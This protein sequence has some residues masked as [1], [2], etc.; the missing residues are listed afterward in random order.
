[1]ANKIEA[2]KQARDGL[3]VFPDLLRYAR[4]GWAA[5]DPDDFERLKWYGLFHRKA[6]P[7]YF[8]LRLRIPNGVLT[9][10]QLTAIGD[11]SNRCGRGQADIT[12]RQNIQLR[13]I[14]I[15]DVPWIFQRLSAAGLTSQ[16]SGMD[17]VANVVGCPLAG[18]DPDELIDSRALAVRLQQAII[19]HKAFSNL[20]RKFNLA[21]TGCRDDCIHA[22]THDLSFVPAVASDG[23][24]VGFNVLAGGAMG[25]REPALARPVDVFVES[26]EVVPAATAILEVF[27]DHGPRESRRSSR[28]KV[29]LK[30]WGM[31]RFREGRRR[32][33]RVAAGARGGAG[34]AAR[35]R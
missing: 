33:R 6:T 28:L 16:Q 2:L 11:I 3:D 8:M 34:D 25:G 14:E 13:W 21:I 7:G 10:E 23:Q 24:T 19:G 15:E 18:L 26:W 20:P 30:A 31:E 29:L 17:N 1:M 35:R 27:R 22:Q 9:S 12:T 4:E 32:A 5:I